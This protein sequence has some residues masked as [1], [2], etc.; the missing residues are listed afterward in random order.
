MIHVRIWEG[1]SATVVDMTNAHKRG[2][3]CRELRFC[4]W[5]PYGDDPKVVTARD[6][7]SGVLGY[8][9]GVSMDAD[10][11]QVRARVIE[12]ILT[13]GFGNDRTVTTYDEE[14]RAIDAP[15]E[16]LKAGVENKWSG[17]ADESGIAIDDL[18]DQIN[19]PCCITSGQTGSRAYELAR[20]VWEQVKACQTFSQAW[21]VL[22]KAGCQLHYFC[23]MD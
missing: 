20:K 16:A 19:L 11:D 22:S 4:G 14:I 1:G 7:T 12:M 6:T 21:D 9:R 10:Y 5:M 18:T 2:K 3:K 17:R 8:L 15:R 23:R 13:A